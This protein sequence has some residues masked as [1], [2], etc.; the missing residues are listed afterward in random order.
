MNSRSTDVIPVE[1]PMAIARAL[2]VLQAD[3]IVAIPTD[4]VYGLAV[5]AFSPQAIERLYLVK[6]R[7]ADKAIPILIAG[8]EALTQVALK[9]TPAAQRLAA[10][11]WPGPL[12]LVL[13]GH[14][15]L[16]SNLSADKTIGVRVPD[17]PAALNL[18]SAAGPLAVT[19]ANL[20]GDPPARLAGEVLQSLRDKIELILD[21]GETPGGQPSTVVNCTGS[22]PDILRRGPISQ[23]E[24]IRVFQN[25]SLS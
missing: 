10:R 25:R 22:Y 1:D 5:R 15:A 24:I 3:G 23:D 11:F 7:E 21:A 2:Q 4:T 6:Q 18:L 14:P 8:L 16:P 13:Y 17:H 19:S 12:T 20:S 9:P